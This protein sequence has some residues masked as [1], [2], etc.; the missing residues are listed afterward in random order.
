MLEAGSSDCRSQRPTTVSEAHRNTPDNL[1]AER[2]HSATAPEVIER[3]ELF[4][5][6]TGRPVG[7]NYAGTVFNHI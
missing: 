2:Q 1:P 3:T 7:E 4:A 5:D 6:D